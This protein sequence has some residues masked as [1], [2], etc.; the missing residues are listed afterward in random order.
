MTTDATRG[1]TW[2]RR[3]C[4][5]CKD[6]YAYGGVHGMCL[7]CDPD[8]VGREYKPL[9]SRPTVDVGGLINEIEGRSWIETDWDNRLIC[10]K[11]LL[12]IIHKHLAL[13]TNNENQDG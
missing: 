6:R 11:D 1:K 5:K 13:L 2:N 8:R 12:P 4:E 7:V 10:V 3:K 9:A